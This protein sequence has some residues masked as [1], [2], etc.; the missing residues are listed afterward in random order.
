MIIID[1]FAKEI[2]CFLDLFQIDISRKDFFHAVVINSSSSL[3]ERS[4]AARAFP[5]D[6]RRRG[7]ARLWLA[8]GLGPLTLPL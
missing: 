8:R 4:L 7:V 3:T 2:N 1:F 6:F 5:C